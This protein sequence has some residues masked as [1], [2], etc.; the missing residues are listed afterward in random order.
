MPSQHHWKPSARRLDNVFSS[1]I[2]VHPGCVEI[3]ADDPAERAEFAVGIVRCVHVR[4]ELPHG[5]FAN[6]HVFVDLPVLLR[7][8]A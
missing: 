7:W 5:F 8:S 2:A 3:T 4:H 1:R 6:A